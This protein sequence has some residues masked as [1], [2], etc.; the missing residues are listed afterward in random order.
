VRSEPK[1]WANHNPMTPEILQSLPDAL[2]AHPYLLIFVGMLV[3]IAYAIADTAGRLDDV[4]HGMEIAFLVFI[5]VAVL[6]HHLVGRWAR[7]KWS[8]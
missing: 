2:L 7:K 6:G 4:V 8:L 3:G 1:S 5:M